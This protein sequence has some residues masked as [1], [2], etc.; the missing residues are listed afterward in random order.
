M[1][2][3][4]SSHKLEDALARLE[5]P[6]APEG[7]LERCLETVPAAKASFRF[8]GRRMLLTRLAG[9][10]A[11]VATIAI[12][13][14]N[15][16]LDWRNRPVAFNTA[17]AE[18]EKLSA[19]VPYWIETGR[20]RSFDVFGKRLGKLNKLHQE[21]FDAAQGHAVLND[22]GETGTRE[23]AVY[24]V[25]LSNGDAYTRFGKSVVGPDGKPFGDNRLEILHNGNEAGK[26]TMSLMRQHITSD[27]LARKTP[28]SVVAEKTL[29]EGT[30][31]GS[32]V[33]I[34]TITESWGNEGV[35]FRKRF[36]A[37]EK[38]ERFIRKET[39]VCF[40]AIG[41]D[42]QQIYEAEIRYEKPEP[43]VF[44]L[45]VLEENAA[46]KSDLWITEE[47]DGYV[48]R[49]GKLV[50]HTPQW[51]TNHP[52]QDWQTFRYPKPVK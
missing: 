37:D 20:A 18:S 32:P 11:V 2:P 28:G 52:G 7:L 49:D 12:V 51:D 5:A 10:L 41:D 13:S 46:S 45:K 15:P 3:D 8:G 16:R 44:D 47:K 21:W 39:H 26:Q 22:W 14:T 27:P 33:K 42:W 23:S 6:P 24:M 34:F 48:N 30:W 4:H 40:S 43:S 50:L 1:N 9:T 36:Y 25:T 35:R 29:V 17:F 38:T 19:A 31:K